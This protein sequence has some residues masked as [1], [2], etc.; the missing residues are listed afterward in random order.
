MKSY[1]LPCAAPDWK[2][3]ALIGMNKSPNS[4]F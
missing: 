2:I 4:L 1:E 3:L